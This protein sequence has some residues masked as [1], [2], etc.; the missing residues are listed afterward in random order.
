M[1]PQS[2]EQARVAVAEAGVIRRKLVA[3]RV[4]PGEGCPGADRA[5]RLALARSARDLLRL[6]LDIDSLALERRSLAELLELPPERA[7]IGVLDGPQQAMGLW[8]ADPAVLAALIEVQ[9]LGKVSASAAAPRKTTRTDAAM[10][11]DFVDATLKALETSLAEDGDLVWAGG[12]RYA[13]FL[14]DPRPLGLLL[15]DEAYLVLRA[16]IALAGGLKSGTLLLALPA[17]G[18]GQIP[19][20]LQAAVTDPAPG[21]SFAELLED[22]VNGADSQMEA[23]LARLTLPI[24]AMMALQPGE[25]LPLPLAAIDRITLEGVDGRR[26]AMGKLGQNRGMRAIRLTP[27]VALTATA[28]PG[29]VLPA[30]ASGHQPMM[31]QTGT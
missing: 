14:D 5:W 28:R 25:V 19:A 7:L 13:S 11:A 29:T 23:V 1:L 18:R 27:E 9:T 6:Q 10:V 30:T 17:E 20:A 3:G 26:L 8:I 24:S 31:R 12:F 2:G 16:Q 4:D 15:E 21:P 22:R